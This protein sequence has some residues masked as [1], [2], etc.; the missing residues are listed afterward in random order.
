MSDY[1]LLGVLLMVIGG[2]STLT[3]VSDYIAWYN[4]GAGMVD[5]NRTLGSATLGILT[6]VLG[7]YLCSVAHRKGKQKRALASKRSAGNDNS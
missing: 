2:W 6:F 5:L 3:S 1:R 7:G 4:L